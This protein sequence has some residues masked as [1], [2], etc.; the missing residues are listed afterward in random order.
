MLTTPK[1]HPPALLLE[2]SGESSE[3]PPTQ[4]FTV[5]LDLTGGEIS[6]SAE[7]DCLKL[8]AV[9]PLGIGQLLSMKILV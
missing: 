7:T 9:E 4:E 2:I 6:S 1:P 5:C 8:A 3:R